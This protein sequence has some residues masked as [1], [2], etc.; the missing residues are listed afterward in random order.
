M[1]IKTKCCFLKEGVDPKILIKYG[2][3]TSN[4]GKSYC[5]DTGEDNLSL[6][7]W[8]KETN[9]FVYK[10][11]KRTSYKFL[12][13]HLIRLIQDGLVEVK[14]TYEWLAIVGRWQDYSL[15]KKALIEAKLEEKN[16]KL[17]KKD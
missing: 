2:F 6:I 3:N 16:N 7:F 12:Y 14:P 15:E 9:R 13:K 10:Y 5:K 4:K 8:F 17:W 11:P 1:Y